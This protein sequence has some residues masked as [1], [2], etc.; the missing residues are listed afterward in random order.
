MRQARTARS[1]LARPGR[2]PGCAG[3]DGAAGPGAEQGLHLDQQGA[4]AL[5]DGHHDAAGDAGH[6]VAQHERP[7]VGHGPQ[8]VV[9]HLEDAHLAGGA[10]AVLDRGQH[11]QGVVAVAVEGEHR[12]DEVLDR[13]GPGG[14]AV[15]G[16]VADHEERHAARLGQAGQALDAGAHLGQAARPAGP[17]GV[18]DRLER[19]DHE[20]RG[21]VALDGRLDRL[22]VGPLER[23]QV[24]GHQ[25][26]ARRPPAH[27]GRA[28]PR[29]RRAGRR[30]RRRRA[31]RA[32]GRGGSTCR[33]RAAR[34]AA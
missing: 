34:R 6:A 1:R 32:P 2:C 16:H 9:A 18:G 11:P 21:V 14:V 30:L 4:A 29:P 20:E 17:V 33:S 23:E 24:T 3:R 8:A 27:L 15:L 7:G 19:V 10:E 22:D 25:A 26:E 5:Q 13:P 31:T 28:T 12:V